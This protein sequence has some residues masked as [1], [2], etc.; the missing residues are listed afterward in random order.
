MP[1]NAER[2]HYRVATG[3]GLN[4]APDP[5]PNPGYKKGG[6]VMPKKPVKRPSGRGR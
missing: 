5:K 1:D 2:Q 6:R 3:Q 4:P